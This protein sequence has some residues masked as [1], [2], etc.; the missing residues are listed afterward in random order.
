MTR[1]H[2][3]AA[4]AI[5]LFDSGVGGLSVW[6]EIRRRLP[7]ESTV[8]FAD[9]AHIPYGPRPPAEVRRYAEA[10]TRELL[11]RGCK[12]IVVAC[13]T[14]SAA[15]LRHL[16]AAFPEV[17]FVGMEPAV[18]P[19]AQTSR[20]RV[21]GV[22]ATPGTLQGPL[23]TELMKRFP[24]VTMINQPC[25][26][27]VE[28]VEAGEL[29]TPQTEALLE[30]FLRPVLGAGADT[31]VLG[32]T[33][34]PFVLRAIRRVAGSTVEIVDPAPAVARQAGRLLAERGLAAPA[35]APAQHAFVTTGDP[36][37]FRRSALALLGQSFTSA[38]V[39]A[40]GW[41]AEDRALGSRSS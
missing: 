14:A 25:P 34:Y 30:T 22:L 9:Q 6:R 37:A 19:A 36:A 3:A 29:D 28:K 11:E 23:F 20:S 2:A 15:A 38:N 5:G 18:K 24:D 8:Y 16:R 21:V 17:P 32:C 10:I 35:G 40:C 33:H 13:N 7:G 4:G 12:L 1:R 26:G 31:V 41:D 27:L 39:L